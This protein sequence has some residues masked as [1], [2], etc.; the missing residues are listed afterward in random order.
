MEKTGVTRFFLGANS[1]RG[2]Y[3]LYDGFTDPAAGDFLW[4]IKGGPGCGK[5]TFMRRI[6]AAAEAVGEPVEYI[7]CSGD[8][9]SLDGVWLPERKTGYVDGTAPHVQEA[10]FPG[11][12]SM[13]L[14]MGRF[15]D[16]RALREKL[17]EIAAVNRQYKAL[18]AQAYALLAGGA[19]LLPENLPGLVGE[20]ERARAEK[21]AAGFAARE[22]RRRSRRS[23]IT[24]R[25]LSAISCRGRIC[26][27]ETVTALAA[28]V[29][30]L[31]N[32]LGLG[33]CFLERLAA[34]AAERGYDLLLCCDPLEPEKPEALLLPEAKL[35]FLAGELPEN[36]GFDPWRRVR[37][38]DLADRNV[39]TEQRSFLR[40]RKRESA[41]LLSRGMKTLA[42]AKALHDSL[43]AL[44]RPHVNF[45]G[46]DALAEEHIAALL[47]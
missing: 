32:Q 8:P 10:V 38:D 18:Y 22:L 29:C 40:E 6:G 9:D 28:K 14:D 26:F 46:A 11:A 12:A 2:F 36:A 39:L 43:E 3:S 35:A 4:V 13:Y 41:L 20:T 37:L 45:A 44:Y 5:S 24:R 27:T 23:R 15:L 42:E 31:D 25:F 33:R 34:L 47:G 17:P 21:R 7:H 1:A 19:A 30:V 16:H